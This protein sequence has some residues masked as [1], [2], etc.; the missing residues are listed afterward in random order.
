MYLHQTAQAI[1]SDKKMRQPKLTHE[2]HTTPIIAATQFQ[3]MLLRKQV[4]LRSMHF[5]LIESKNAYLSLRSKYEIMSRLYFTIFRQ[6][7]QSK[8]PYRYLGNMHIA[9]CIISNQT[10]IDKRQPTY[11]PHNPFAITKGVIG[12]YYDYL[13]L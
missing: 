5:Y 1:V 13:N 11:N 4:W 9:G 6:V 2:K 3:Y 12:G 8:I 7:A 10:S